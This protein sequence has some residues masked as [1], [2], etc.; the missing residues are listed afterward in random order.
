MSKQFNT[1]IQHKIDTYENWGKAENFIPLLG[2]L[3]IYT[4]NEKGEAETKIKIGDGTTNVNDL[5]FAVAGSASGETEFAQSDWAQTDS[6]AADYIKNKPG[7]EIKEEEIINFVENYQ[8]QE[9]QEV[10]PSVFM[11]GTTFGEITPQIDEKVRMFVKTPDN[12]NIFI[13]EETLYHDA[14]LQEAMGGVNDGPWA[15]CTINSTVKNAAEI[16][17]TGNLPVADE[18]IP[19][20]FVIVIT[21]DEQGGGYITI[22]STENLAGLNITLQRIETKLT[23]IKLANNALNIDLEPIENSDN[24]ITSGTIYN[25]FSNLPKIQFI[26]WEEND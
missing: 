11:L 22:V 10:I 12:E 3:I 23:T 6:Q 18:T 24:L 20:A 19:Y 14:I 1:R 15:C 21:P 26:T 2:E 4:T 13:G 7:D 5:E 8:L 25:Y 17:Q 16:L 9:G